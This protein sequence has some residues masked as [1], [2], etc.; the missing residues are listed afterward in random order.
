[1]SCSAAATGGGLAAAH[2]VAVRSSSSFTWIHLC[3]CAW[4]T[5]CVLSFLVLDGP[6]HNYCEGWGVSVEK[7]IH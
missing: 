7:A 3:I 5:I 4:L 2:Q 1:M 6:E